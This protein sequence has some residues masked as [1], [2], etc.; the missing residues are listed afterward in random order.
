MMRTRTPLSRVK[1]LGSAKEGTDHFWHQRVTAVANI[2]LS[3]FLLYALITNIGADYQTVKA[4]MSSPLVCVAFLA[5]ILSGVIHMRLGMQVIIEDYVH[6]EAS[7]IL[8]L[9]L[10][11]FFAITIG[12]TCIYAVL[13]LS[14]GA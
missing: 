14:F 9:I 4:F 2:F 1:G 13:K 7:K 8:L 6:N 12:L 11:S 10:N 3:G 5:T